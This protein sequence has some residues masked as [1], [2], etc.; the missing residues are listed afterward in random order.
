MSHNPVAGGSFGSALPFV[1][2]WEGGFVDL[3]ADH[4]G[5]TNR[6]ITQAVYDRWRNETGKP[7]RDVRQLRDDELEGIY[8][9]NYWQPAHCEVLAPPLALAHFDTAVNMGCGRAVRFLQQALGC[10]VDGQFGDA[11]RR[12]AEACQAGSTVALYCSAREALYRAIVQ[13]K[14]NQ[15][16]FLKGW[17]NRLNDLRAVVGVAGFT[18]PATR[19]RSTPPE[20]DFGDTGYIARVADGADDD[21]G[22]EPP[23]VGRHR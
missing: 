17:M 4:G 9:A 23:P 11:T 20:P 18:R 13:N 5:A 22:L 19:G 14:P 1:L 3:A 7:A 2:R 12:S 10:G 6:G 15:A 21:P 16:V 8:L